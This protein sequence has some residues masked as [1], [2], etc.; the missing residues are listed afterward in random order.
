M[1]W[2][3]SSKSYIMLLNTRARMPHLVSAFT[4]ASVTRYHL[5]GA[6]MLLLLLQLK[7]F[8]SSS[9]YLSTGKRERTALVKAKQHRKCRP[10]GTISGPSLGTWA[11]DTARSD[12][13]TLMGSGCQ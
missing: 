10:D 1:P 5:R 4:T 11:V 7:K 3:A 9:G 13:I 6:G 8:Y 2:R 12:S